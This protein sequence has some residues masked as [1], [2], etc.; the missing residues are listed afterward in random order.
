MIF[1][2][3]LIEVLVSAAVLGYET[4]AFPLDPIYSTCTAARA[5]GYGP[6]D[7]KDPEYKH[8]RDEDHNGQV[9]E[10]PW[11]EGRFQP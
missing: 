9:C 6:Y 2:A 7:R 11:F 1:V 10:G 3:L 5:N 8:Y 4:A